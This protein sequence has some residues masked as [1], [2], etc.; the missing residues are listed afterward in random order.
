MSNDTKVYYEKREFLNKEATSS[1]VIISSVTSY[2]NKDYAG[3]DNMLKISDCSK[4]IYLDLDCSDEVTY[5]E[6]ID[7]LK[8]IDNVINQTLKALALQRLELTIE[9]KKIESKDKKTA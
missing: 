5:Q 1:S 7:K 9:Q 8:L 6:V 3:T 2:T 4:S